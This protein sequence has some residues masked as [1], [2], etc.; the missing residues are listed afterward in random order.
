MTILEILLALSFII[1]CAY[2]VIPKFTKLYKFL[3]KAFL[4]IDEEKV[5]KP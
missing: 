1:Y 5:K 3:K 4:G 2:L